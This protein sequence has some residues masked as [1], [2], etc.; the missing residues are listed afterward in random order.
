[1]QCFV[2]LREYTAFTCRV[3]PFAE[4]DAD[5]MQWNS[6][7]WL[8]REVWGNLANCSHR[9][10]DGH[11]TTQHWPRPL[12]HAEQHRYPGRKIQGHGPA[13]KWCDRNQSRVSLS[14]LLDSHALSWKTKVARI[15]Y[16]K[17]RSALLRQHH[18]TSTKTPT[19]IL[20]QWPLSTSHSFQSFLSIHQTQY[21]FWYAIPLPAVW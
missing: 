11:G 2:T 19:G 3:T 1:M 13:H 8:H 6:M 18:L 15:L 21:C 4:D 7:C 16:E 17:E 20:C 14:K 5:I 10:E 12:N 9:K